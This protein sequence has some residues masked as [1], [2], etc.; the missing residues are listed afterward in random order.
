MDVESKVQAIVFGALTN[1]NEEQADGDQIALDRSSVL[2]GD[3]STVDSL[4]LVSVIVDVET[5]LSSEFDTPVALTDDR[6]MSR[7]PSPF[8]TVGTLIDYI[9]ELLQE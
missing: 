1:L 6:A 8:D 3:N 9:T 5:E 4:A 2:F 7:Q